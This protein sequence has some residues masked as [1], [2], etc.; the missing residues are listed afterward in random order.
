MDVASKT[1]SF[2]EK[3]VPKYQLHL[4]YRKVDREEYHKLPKVIEG[5]EGAKSRQK[6]EV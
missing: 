6:T 5:L 3:I 2:D 4:N 1:A